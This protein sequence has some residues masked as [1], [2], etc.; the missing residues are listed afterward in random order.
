MTPE[1]T[2]PAPEVRKTGHRWVD[3]LLTFSAITMSAISLYLARDN[4]QAMERLVQANS[5]PFVQ[6][7]SGN[8]T[9]D[10]VPGVLSF[11]ARNA[12]TGPAQ[13]YSFAV[14]VDG[15]PVP[16]NGWLI[17]NLASACCGEEWTA[18]AAQDDVLAAVGPDLTSPVARTLLAPGDDAT[19]LRWARTPTNQT[20]WIAIDRARQ[21]GR[22]T[23][24]ACYCSLFDECW[25]A[26]TNV[27]PPQQVDSCTS[28]TNEPDAP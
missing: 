26:E 20:L 18:I 23:M 9:D 2:E 21:E 5:R 13:I 14:L 28:E 4:S 24:R 10:G 8:A 7:G 6:L 27:F 17:Q 22:I 11:A 15:Q 25:I 12:G 16:Q 1:T 19:A 3:L